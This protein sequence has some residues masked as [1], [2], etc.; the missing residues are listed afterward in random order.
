MSNGVGK[1]PTLSPCLAYKDF[2]KITHLATLL[3]TLGCLLQPTYSIMTLYKNTIENYL[4]E[5]YVIGVFR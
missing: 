5:I 4:N 1:N 3:D 2:V